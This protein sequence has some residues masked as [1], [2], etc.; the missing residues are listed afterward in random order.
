MTLP[1]YQVDAFADKLFS[2]NPAAVVPLQEWLPDALMQQ[3]ALENNLSETVFFVPS[4]NEEWDYDIRWF[5]PEVEINLCGHATLASAYVLFT[6]LHF[7][8]EKLVF[9]SKS[10][11]LTI[12]QQ[13]DWFLMD[14]PSWKPKTATDFPQKLQ[15][16][17]GGV[18]IESVHR[19]REWIA[20]LKDE[21]A[22]KA[23]QPNFLLMQSIPEMVI[24]TA[25]GTEIDFVS[26]FFAPGS[27][28]NEDPVTGSAHSQLIPYWSEVLGKTE[29]I[30][31]QLS[32]RG[33]TL[34]CRQINEE[35]VEIGGQCVFYLKGEIYI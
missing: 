31:R 10:G 11:L 24:I 6:Q 35:R 5:T 12:H 8:K 15:E 16:A 14:F 33:G 30:A 18:A 3:I 4:T 21:A 23:C 7:A 27:A 19:H 1:I 13:G 9:H 2:G 26:R 29:M 25:K 22:V 28:I 32:Q 17:L 34:R 20:V